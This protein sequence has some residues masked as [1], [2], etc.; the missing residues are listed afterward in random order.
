MN[1]RRCGV[2]L[3]HTHRFRYS[4]DH[5]ISRNGL[6]VNKVPNKTIK[7]PKMDSSLI[8]MHVRGDRS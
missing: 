8:Y 2:D 6:A 1:K 4:D 3:M 5:V 7:R